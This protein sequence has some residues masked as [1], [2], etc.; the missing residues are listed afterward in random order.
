M[1]FKK[2]FLVA[3]T[4]GVLLS[5]GPS[6]VS[7][8][9]ETPQGYERIISYDTI[10]K[11]NTD[12]G[13]L[14]SEQI[15]VESTGSQ[16]RRGIYRDFPTIYTNEFG[17]KQ[18]TSF[19]LKS[20]EKDGVSEPYHIENQTNG[21]RLY[22]GEENTFLTPGIYTY[23]IVYETDRQLGYFADHDELFF[24]VVGN[25]WSFPVES[26]S[27]IVALP[28]S[29]KDSELVLDAFTGFQGEKGKAF[30][31][32]TGKEHGTVIAFF[33]TNNTLYTGEGFT[34][35]VEF[36]KGVVS[37]PDPI[38]SLSA[39]MFDNLFIVITGLGL[40]G[41]FV[42][43][44][45]MWLL[46]GRDPVGGTIIPLFKPP[47]DLSPA[48]VRY[49]LEM[50]FDDK[51]IAVSVL[52]MG[53][54]GFL[55]IKEGSSYYTIEKN[56]TSKQGELFGEEQAIYDQYFSSSDSLTFK[57]RNHARVNRGK[58]ALKDFLEKQ[59]S[60]LIVT[61]SSFLWGGIVFSVVYILIAISYQVMRFPNEDFISGI[62]MTVFFLAPAAIMFKTDFL[63][64]L[65]L[66]FVKP[67]CSILMKVFSFSFAALFL[68]PGL[69]GIIL[70]SQSIG[71]LGFIL[72]S[73]PVVLHF[74]YHDALKAVTRAGKKVK[75]QIDGF[76]M[77]LLATEKERL[78]IMHKKLPQTLETYERFLPYA[79]AMNIE[80]Q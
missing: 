25:G 28:G 3:I 63:P 73:I 37:G 42:Y 18:S 15:K 24:N 13:L 44:F 50:G 36:P 12:G 16:I 10:I 43:Y 34:I 60:N 80:S 75:D 74:I 56:K 79:V 14:V 2:L 6:Y 49:I 20:V 8:Q 40:T 67:S 46:Y 11:I 38:S 65:K 71:L 22:I 27:A 33:E 39:L 31:S 58:D 77:Y 1:L 29:I 21:P 53:V 54:Q 69:A 57:N 9:F 51:A 35:L 72:V 19:D 76:K 59:Y 55:N 5:I 70:M 52:S 62:F 66:L 45:I 64:N 48:A 26:A 23:R 7:A 4:I 61:N 68:L 32:G 30:I 41:L 17:L 78:A 47:K